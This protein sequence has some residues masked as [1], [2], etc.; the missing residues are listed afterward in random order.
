[1]AQVGADARK[2]C[3]T[4][5]T[6]FVRIKRRL[7][8]AQ[9][10]HSQ[11]PQVQEVCE[12]AG[13]KV[14]DRLAGPK[15]RRREESEEASSGGAGEPAAKKVKRGGPAFGRGHSIF[16]SGTLYWC[17]QCGAYAEQRFKALKLPCQ[18]S[19]AQSQ[20]EGQLG[21]MRRGLHPVKHER[22]GPR[23]RLT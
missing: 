14:V 10:A 5:E 17:E 7:R 3:T 9:A 2:G 4:V 8:E 18:G 16:L 21:R 20:R 19:E 6:A 11:T 23:R 22:I 12:K 1:M 15:R 13:G